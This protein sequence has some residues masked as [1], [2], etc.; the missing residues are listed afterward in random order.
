LVFR[1]NLEFILVFFCHFCGHRGIYFPFWFVKP[2][3]PGLEKKKQRRAGKGSG[4]LMKI[5][6]APAGPNFQRHFRSVIKVR[7]SELAF[8]NFPESSF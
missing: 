5:S 7:Q 4:L 8:G 1:D 2:G 3:N 6:S